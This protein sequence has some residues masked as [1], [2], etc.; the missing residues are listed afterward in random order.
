[1]NV[2]PNS[3][4]DITSSSWQDNPINYPTNYTCSQTYVLKAVPKAGYVF[5]RWDGS[6][7]G[8]S[9][10]LTVS[11]ADG[12]KSVTAYF[13]LKGEEG[14]GHSVNEVNCNEHDPLSQ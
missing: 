12:A 10:P 3:S 14:D 5:D 13:K 11:V 8:S 9:N 1:M 7:S 2:S 4:G 6:N